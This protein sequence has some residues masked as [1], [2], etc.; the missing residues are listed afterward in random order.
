MQNLRGVQS[1]SEAGGCYH[2]HAFPKECKTGRQVVEMKEMFCHGLVKRSEKGTKPSGAKRQ[3]SLLDHWKKEDCVTNDDGAKKANVLW[4][5]VVDSEDDD[6]VVILESED[7]EVEKDENSSSKLKPREKDDMTDIQQ[8]KGK[9][10][11]TK[12]GNYL[13][14]VT[15]YYVRNFLHVCENAI[16]RHGSI[17]YEKEVALFNEWRNNLSLGAQMIYV[18]CYMRSGPWFRENDL[19]KKYDEQMPGMKVGECISEL[20]SKKWMVEYDASCHDANEMMSTMSRPELSLICDHLNAWKLH[21]IKKSSKK[22]EMISVLEK[23]I[24]QRSVFEQW[25]KGI[26]SKHSLV[27]RQALQFCTRIVSLSQE[28]VSLF[29]MLERLSFLFCGEDLF[30]LVLSNLSVCTFPEYKI[31]EGD[32]PVFET[33]DALDDYF[34]S[35]QVRDELLE[36]VEQNDPQKC[37]ELLQNCICPRLEEQERNLERECS[38]MKLTVE[39]RGKMHEFQIFRRFTSGYV[40]SCA[41]TAAISL[42]EK[43]GEY[44]IVVDALQ[45]VV[46]THFS[47]GRRG[48]WWTRLALDLMHIRRKEDA[49]DVLVRALNDENVSLADRTR[50]SRA[51]SFGH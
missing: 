45:M 38:A 41:L 25:G 39:E 44:D 35:L 36:I 32:R 19:E 9:D 17:M 6:S 48:F 7:D 24:H 4:Y 43:H 33:R 40:Y 13:T 22:E 3:G 26:P 31:W 18:R 15:P 34:T 16:E 42:L 29:Q 8:E 5:E 30:S 47:I 37:R 2:K 49:L 10:K 46:K 1:L 14:H 51:S 20:I 23:S 27:L 28:S 12:S 11:D 21:G 50:T